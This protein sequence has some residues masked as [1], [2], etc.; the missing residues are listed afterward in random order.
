MQSEFDYS[1]LSDRHW[2]RLH[3]LILA[4]GTQAECMSP[5][6]NSGALY[7]C[8]EI[9]GGIVIAEDGNLYPPEDVIYHA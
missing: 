9:A 6:H 3:H 8:L 4:L 7:Y 5:S 2:P 1:L